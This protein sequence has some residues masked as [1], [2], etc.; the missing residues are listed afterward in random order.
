MKLSLNNQKKKPPISK[1]FLSE[2]N[3][4]AENEIA[5]ERNNIDLLIEEGSLLAEQEKFSDAIGKWNQAICISP[6]DYRIYEMKAQALLALNQPLSAIKCV[7]EA[8]LLK[9]DWS[10]GLQTLGRCQRDIGELQL[11]FN[12]FSKA[13]EID[14]TNEEIKKEKLEV[15]RLLET[16]IQYR[17]SFY[18]QIDS[19]EGDDQEEVNRCFYNLSARATC[20]RKTF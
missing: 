9:S 2:E 12:S 3:Q 4:L 6:K 11:A 14:P 13:L 15:K 7:E 18:N 20:L 10:L 1:L 8:L 17:Q 19:S 5:N 16:L